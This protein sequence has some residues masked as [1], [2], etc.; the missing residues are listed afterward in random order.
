M[1]GIVYLFGPDWTALDLASVAGGL[2]F[3]A[4]ALAGAVWL[5]KYRWELN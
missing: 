2:A 3:A 1:I 4:V 5:R